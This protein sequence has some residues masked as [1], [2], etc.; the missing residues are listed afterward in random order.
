MQGLIAVAQGCTK[1]IDVDMDGCDGLD[2]AAVCELVRH[3][4]RLK[5]IGCPNKVTDIAAIAIA[6]GCP[7]LTD[8][9]LRDSFVTDK[10][11]V[12]LA[13]HCRKLRHLN[14]S[15]CVD[16]IH[17]QTLRVLVDKCAK[18]ESIA[19]PAFFRHSDEGL[20]RL[21]GRCGDKYLHLWRE[22]GFTYD[23]SDESGSDSQSQSDIDSN[24]EFESDYSS[25]EEEDDS[26]LDNL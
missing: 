2:D 26:W 7:D 21:Q 25:D 24:S 3:C 23:A 18:L 19:L 10:G 8:L 14:M 16:V 11:A 17:L 20:P 9:T 15:G 22:S 13:T 4:A 1:L 12:A 5:I 6:Q